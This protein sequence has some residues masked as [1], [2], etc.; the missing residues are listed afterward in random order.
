MVSAGDQAGHDLGAITN[1]L[2]P[3]DESDDI[4]NDRVGEPLRGYEAGAGT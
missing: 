4:E 1:D 2:D 3:L